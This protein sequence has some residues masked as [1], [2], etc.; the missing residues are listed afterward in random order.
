MKKLSVFLFIISVVILTGCDW[1]SSQKTTTTDFVDQTTIHDNTTEEEIHLTTTEQ[2]PITTTTNGVVVTTTTEWVDQTTTAA[3][4]TASWTEVANAV[5][6]A[7]N[8]VFLSQYYNF[9]CLYRYDMTE[10]ASGGAVIDY[11]QGELNISYD[12]INNK[13]YIAV[14]DTDDYNLMY[15]FDSQRDLMYSYV[16]DGGNLYKDVIYGDDLGEYLDLLLSEDSGTFVAIYTLFELPETSVFQVLGNNTYGISFSIYDLFENHYDYA[17]YVL[18]L[19]EPAA[20]SNDYYVNLVFDLNHGIRLIMETNRYP[21]DFLGIKLYTQIFYDEQMYIVDSF[22]PETINEEHYYETTFSEPQYCDRSY[23]ADNTHEVLILPETDNYFR[24]EL[25]S[26]IY[27]ID[28]YW[29]FSNKFHSTLYDSD[30]MVVPYDGFY[31]IEEGG[32]YYLNVTTDEDDETRLEMTF[33]TYP[34]EQVGTVDSPILS[35]N[36]LTGSIAMGERAYYYL[37]TDSEAGYLEI[38]M[39]D[40]DFGWIWVSNGISTKMLWVSDKVGFIVEEGQDLIIILSGEFEVFNFTVS[41]EFKEIPELI[42]D[43]NL[44]PENII[45]SR[46]IIAIGEPDYSQA[47]K[48]IITEEADYSLYP[49]FDSVPYM[50]FI[51]TSQLYDDQGTLLLEYENDIEWHLTPGTYYVIVTGN[52]S[53]T[54]ILNYVI[55]KITP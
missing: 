52:G 30:M 43:I 45:G 41:W 20:S 11:Y 32:T 29:D 8:E 7:Y 40:G 34:E 38:T 3:E 1:F 12:S 4:G 24:F 23:D 14:E 44:M 6:V 10:Y 22:D 27:N 26:G 55:T 48:F 18:G 19:I 53:E 50:D 21:V 15:T 2:L 49:F 25:D 37:L 33:V 42:T 16:I 28:L 36:E 9:D 39:T 47:I 54:F 5:G 13:S 17:A 31:R 51:F 35:G 46:S